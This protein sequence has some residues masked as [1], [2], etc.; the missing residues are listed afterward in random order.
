MVLD[1]AEVRTVLPQRYSMLLIDRV[2]AI[3]SGAFIRAIKAVTVGEP[4]YHGLPEGLA[5]QRYAYPVGLLLES[6]GQAAAILWLTSAGPEARGELLLFGAARDC[7]IEG[8]AYPG[9]VLRHEARLEQVT[10]GAAF[11]SGETW[12]GRRRIARIGSLMAVTR[13]G[14]ALQPSPTIGP[15]ANSEGDH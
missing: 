13:P 3:E 12:A 9:D 15:V 10:D 11:V 2:L 4:C 1:H 8:R 14:S 6:F 7:L 5:A